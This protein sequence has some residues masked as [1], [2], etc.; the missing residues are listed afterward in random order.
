M[1]GWRRLSLCLTVLALLAGATDCAGGGGGRV[2]VRVA[3]SDLTAADVAQRMSIIAPE[4]IVPDPPRYKSCVAHLQ[5]QM[6]QSIASALEEECRQQYQALKQRALGLLISWHWLIGEAIERG[7]Q[8]RDAQLATKAQ[9]AEAKIRQALKDS[10]AKITQAQIEAYYKQ[11]AGRFGRRERR[12][13]DI[14]ERLP[15]KAAARRALSD[16]MRR[17][18]MAQVAIHESFDEM[19]IAQVEPRRK[20]ILRAIFAARPHMLVGPLPLLNREWCF[21][22]VTRVIPAVVKPLAQVQ[23]TI[24]QRLAGERRWRTLAN[25]ISAWRR[26]W[27][28]RTDCS[29]GYEVQKCREYRGPKTPEDPLAFN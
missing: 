17:G 1:K 15:S 12:Y 23:A 27:I 16:I 11:N 14:V 25:F 7:L 19:S 4:H 9:A 13:I 29:A 26:K 8:L 22:E 10:E 5:A 24:E 18:N 2:A 28:A 21:F 6:P 3:Q 20:A